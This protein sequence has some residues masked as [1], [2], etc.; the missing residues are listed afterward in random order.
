MLYSVPNFIKGP[1]YI[2]YFCNNLTAN[3]IIGN[4]FLLFMKIPKV[5][6]SFEINQ[7]YIFTNYERHEN[8]FICRNN[9]VNLEYYQLN[10]NKNQHYK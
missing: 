9:F 4:L 6:S 3:K 2:F 8:A 7:C 10:K 5:L 1:T